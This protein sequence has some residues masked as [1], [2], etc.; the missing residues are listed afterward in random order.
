MDPK[1]DYQY[2]LIL[3]K[4]DFKKKKIYSITPISIPN[5]LLKYDGKPYNDLELKVVN[6]LYKSGA[7]FPSYQIVEAL[8]KGGIN[9]L[10]NEDTLQVSIY[11]DEEKEGDYQKIS[12]SLIK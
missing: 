2:D 6:Q 7:L 3:P 10:T 11:P 9:S 4:L 12:I 5:P 1:I 8:K